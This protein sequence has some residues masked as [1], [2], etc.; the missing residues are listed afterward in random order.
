MNHVFLSLGT[1]L[2][3]RR[4]NLQRAVSG[5]TAAMR[6]TAV[7]PLY[8]TS[9]WGLPDQPDF[10]NLCLAG[11]TRLSPPSL[12]TF[13]K[14]LESEIGRQPA[15]RWGPRLI[16]IDLLFYDNLIIDDVYLTVPHP[17][18]HE[19]PFVLVPMADIAPDFVHPLYGMTVTQ[20]A[21]AVDMVGVKQ[22]SDF[23]LEIS[24]VG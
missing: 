21:A 24:I 20:M 4:R 9:P 11:K 3:Q 5:L 12:L 10:L 13:A 14:N 15:E 23:S 16:D 7:S 8:E 1:N 18:L 2:G 19:R 6:I 22:R 17:R